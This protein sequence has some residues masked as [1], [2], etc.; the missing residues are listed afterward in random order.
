[1]RRKYTAT[2]RQTVVLEWP[3]QL[4]HALHLFC[5]IAAS[6][7]SRNVATQQIL[8]AYGREIFG[9]LYFTEPI[10]T[11]LV[12]VAVGWLG[13]NLDTRRVTRSVHVGVAVLMAAAFVAPTFR[14]EV[15][16]ARYILMELVFAVMLL[17]FGLTM[18]AALGPREARKVAARIGVGGI[19]G[20]IVAGLVLMAG[21]LLVGSRALY[22]VAAGFAL[23]PVFFLPSSTSSPGQR[24]KIPRTELQRERG[25]VSALAPYGSWVAVTTILMVAATT[26]IDY[27]YRTTSAQ[28][29]GRGDKVTAFFGLVTIL[30]DVLTLVFQLAILDRLLN[31]LGLFGTSIIMPASLMACLTS[32]GLAPAV[33][34]LLVLKV[35]DSGSN[36]SVQQATGNLLLAPLSSR[37][38]SVWQSRIDGVAKRGGKMLMGIF[39]SVFPWGAGRVLPVNV[40]L[41]VLWLAAI[42]F[43]RTRYV[44]LLTEMLGAPPST[45]P[46]VEALDGATLRL[47]ETELAKSA[48]ERAAVIL[49]LLEKADHRAPEH[50]LK[51][52]VD[53]D[54]NGVGAF[55]VIEHVA[56]LGDTK[57]LIE[58][59]QSP[60]PEIAAAS[61][62]ALWDLDPRLAAPRCKQ[63]LLAER[64]PEL[65]AATTAGLLAEHDSAALKL[66]KR[67]AL[68]SERQTRLAVCRSLGRNQAG[69]PIEVGHLLADL[70]RDDDP[71]IARVALE[72]IGRH[73]TETSSDVAI[74]ALK[75]RD[76]RGAAM[77]AL[78]EMGPA[79]VP[80]LADELS[81]HL[82]DPAI[83]NALTWS[84]GRVSAA[85]GVP[86]LLKALQASIVQV[87]LGAAVALSSLHRRQPGVSLPRELIEKLSLTEI[88]YYGMMRHAART[89]L[90]ATPGSTLLLRSLK[91]RTQASLETLFRMLSVH[92]PEEAM[93]GAFAAMSQSDARKRQIALELLDTVLSKPLKDALAEAV[94]GAHAKESEHHEPPRLL[95]FLVQGPDRFLASLSR[96][97][98]G[99]VAE[100]AGEPRRQADEGETMTQSQVAQI[101]ELQSL[102]LFSQTTAEDLAEVASLVAARRTEKGTILFREGEPGDAMYLVRGGE[103]TLSRGGQ[104]I[105]HVGAGEACGIVSV[106]DQLP[107]E[108]TAAVTMDATLLVIR[109]DDLMQ[110]LADRP[111]LMHSVFRA[112]TNALRSQLDRVSLGKKA[113][114]WSW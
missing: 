17:T 14:P 108:A 4:K 57:A 112:L 87:R 75:R 59:V 96:V 12:V 107:R 76:V 60:H 114:E 1:M 64:V 13:R 27:V 63:I 5:V 29:F 95:S 80:R 32:F 23:A 37:A 71:E 16:I 10:I 22:L 100:V 73:P 44:R 35:V 20:G 53:A 98:L 54:P 109:G 86:P 78:A 43:T 39:L 15:A 47:L 92:Y 110:L 83:A 36:M 70:V 24:A 7:I 9:K 56:S 38:R 45:R 11:G 55:R 93:Q 19:V 74:S 52:L 26:L 50:I 8:S 88:A 28:Y 94:G 97:V 111:L 21:A 31:R 102:S 67:L 2:M 51:R 84:I 69:A 62:L 3:S 79:V 25:D 65:L 42:L 72:A 85:T 40:I 106:L 41:C 66:C 105:D 99:D 33:A 34:T 6:V 81:L 89:P 104:I 77:R 103:I 101:L 82:E 18:G 90:P 46:E 58:L 48:P 30:A 91:Q 61:L 49:D 113:E 68:A